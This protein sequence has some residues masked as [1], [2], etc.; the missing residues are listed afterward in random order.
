LFHAKCYFLINF[1]TQSPINRLG[2]YQAAKYVLCK[3][4]SLIIFQHD[5]FLQLERYEWVFFKMMRVF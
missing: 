1:D 3:S 2:I 5:F 4:Y